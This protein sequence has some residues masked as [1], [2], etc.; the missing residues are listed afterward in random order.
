MSGAARPY[1][2]FAFASVH[3]ALAAEAVLRGAGI[4]VTVIPS[5]REL[6]DLCGIA[7]RVVP[8]DAASAERCLAD[9]GAEPRARADILDL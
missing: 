8:D 4:A 6:G 5:P 2:A 7:M 1:V 3:D 9:A